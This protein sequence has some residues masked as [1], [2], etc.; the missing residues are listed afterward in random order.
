MILS[1]GEEAQALELVT[2]EFDL[3]LK[4][5]HFFGKTPVG[6]FLCAIYF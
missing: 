5:Q 2:P 3:P 6:I 4:S 1:P